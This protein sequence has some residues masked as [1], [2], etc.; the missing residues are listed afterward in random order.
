MPLREFVDEDGTVWLAWSTFPRSGANVRPAFAD[1]WLSFQTGGGE[2]RRRLVPVP[3][4]WEAA[5]ENE[6]RAYLRRASPTERAESLSGTAQAMAQKRE[7]AVAE[8]LERD[9]AERIRAD[10]RTPSSNGGALERI[11]RILRG[12]R[13]E[14]DDGP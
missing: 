4:G 8:I 2:D 7:E 9:R 1:G 3:Q 11:R 6:L 14:R 5:S 12:I 13:V 10:P